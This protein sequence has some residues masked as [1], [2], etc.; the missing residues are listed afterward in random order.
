MKIIIPAA[1][2]GT[3]LRP[4]TYTDPKVLLNVAGKPILAH[5]LDNLV[6]LKPTE[7]IFIIGFLGQK[8]IDFV[9][10]NYK[11]K[12]NFVEQKK[13]LGLGHAIYLTSNFITEEPVLIILGD[14]I[15]E[16]NLKF[17]LKS[18]TNLLGTC[19][20][21]DPQRFGI[22]EVKN[23]WV[24]K[25]TEKP[26]R[27]KGN[28]ALVGVYYIK[29][30]GLF[31]QG[32]KEVVEKGQ[33][34]KGEYQLTDVLQK[35]IEKKAKFKTFKVQGWYDCGKIETLLE[36]NRHLLMRKSFLP[37]HKNFTGSLILPPV[38]IS[39]QAQIEHSVIGPFVTVTDKARV[40]NSVVFDAIVNEK[41][42]VRHSILNSQV[43]SKNAKI[44]QNNWPFTSLS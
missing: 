21:D 2:V 33:K 39:P 18:K 1:G 14:T 13:L 22:A 42:Q 44:C 24:T 29:D 28:L 30:T 41:A 40:K 7:V 26:K 23:G 4:H 34:T 35:M 37:S 20:V 19:P 27:P 5:I 15:I 11:F 3:R 17:I 38:F 10:K 25:L 8:I 16:S 9:K 32:L 6:A 31:K 43:V 36:T 12:S